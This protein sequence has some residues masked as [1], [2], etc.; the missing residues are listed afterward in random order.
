M[1]KKGILTVI[2]GYLLIGPLC[3][4]GEELTSDEIMD[5]LEARYNVEGFFVR[6]HQTSTNMALNITESAEGNIYIRQPGCM[7]MEYEQ[8]EEQL[9]VTNGKSLW[10][11]RPVDNQ[12][13]M[14]KAET[15]FGESNGLAFLSDITLIRKNF[16]IERLSD[17]SSGYHVLK[18]TPN[19]PSGD[20]QAIYLTALKGSFEVLQIVNEN[21]YGNETRYTFETPELD[22]ELNDE[23]FVFFPPTGA[24][25]VLLEE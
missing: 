18:L 3:A 7:R 1:M 16:I 21:A 13:M 8:P 4:A 10:Y 15:F 22:R 2:I 24:E 17:E 20:I 23:M 19:T 6:F 9:V 14:G 25:I 5:G 12:V 11:Y